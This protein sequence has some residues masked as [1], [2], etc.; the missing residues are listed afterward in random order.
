MSAESVPESSQH[1]VVSGGCLCG[2]VRYEARPTHREGY[3]CHCRMCQLAFGNTRATYLNLRKDQ[4]RWTSEPPTRYPSSK[5]AVRSFCSRCGTP[6]SFEF[7]AS[8][9]MDLSVGSL[10]HPE[11]FSP[12]SHFAV[13]SR[14]ANW[15]VDDGLPGQRLDASEP[16]MKRWRDAYGD[17]VEPGLAATESATTGAPAPAAAEPPKPA[18]TL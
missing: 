15:H 14:I 8:D 11:D 6:L 10:D 4:V 17:D 18:P 5:I 1:D 7:L 3:Y 9:H 12:V 13:E 2:Q 16:I